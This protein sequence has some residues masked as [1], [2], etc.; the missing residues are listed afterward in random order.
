M[1]E[2]RRDTL[3]RYQQNKDVR[4]G[5]DVNFGAVDMNFDMSG[6]TCND[7]RYMCV[8]LKKGDR[9]R[10]EYEMT[11]VPNDDVLK[12]SFRHKCEG[13][14]LVDVIC[15][16][17]KRNESLVENFNFNFLTPL[18]QTLKMLHFDANPITIWY[19]VTELWRIWQC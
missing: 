17:I 16:M 13:E 3:S 9:P 8:E 1:N 11:A 18:S 5:D 7:V 2:Q 4:P 6:L 14:C 10:P 15:D 12:K 19:L